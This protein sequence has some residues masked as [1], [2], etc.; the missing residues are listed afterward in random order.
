MHPPQDNTPDMQ[1]DE[2]QCNIGPTT[3][4]NHTAINRDEVPRNT[5]PHGNSAITST[6]ASS[7]SDYPRPGA[8]LHSKPR[9]GN[10]RNTN[11]DVLKT[12][13]QKR[14]FEAI[15]PPKTVTTHELS[16]TELYLAERVGIGDI[17]TL[18]SGNE[19]GYEQITLSGILTDINKKE[20]HYNLPR[21]KHTVSLEKLYV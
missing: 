18:Q 3:S 10:Q 1:N 20:N 8:E 17:T 6:N 9:I 13:L 5:T 15:T 4:G 16:A 21:S 11:Y 14:L 2:K 7:S 19:H 12:Y